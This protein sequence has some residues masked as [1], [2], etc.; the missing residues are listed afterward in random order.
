MLIELHPMPKHHGPGRGQLRGFM[1]SPEFDQEKFYAYLRQCPTPHAQEF[2]CHFFPSLPSTNTTLA[3]LL[4]QGAPSGTVV[5][6]GEQSAGRG[7]RGRVWES[8]PGGLYLS[9][10]LALSPDQGAWLTLWSAWGIATVL[11]RQGIPLQLKWP[12]DLILGGQ[13]LGGILTETYT[14][15]PQQWA[16]VG[17]GVNWENPV[18]AMGINL[19][20]FL[21]PDR[22]SLAAGL[23][24]EWLA[25]LVVQGVVLGHHVGEHSD[26]A[27]FFQVYQGLLMSSP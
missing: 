26:P 11:Q 9:L 22:G 4:R 19:R 25:A 5:I 2:H 21:P 12:N 10:G 7:Q 23:S 14:W 17:V 13:K 24:L 8:L 15:G 3:Q 16:V 18:P 1:S 6:A 27:E 20:S